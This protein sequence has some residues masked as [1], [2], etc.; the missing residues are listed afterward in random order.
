MDISV[1]FEPVLAALT[2]ACHFFIFGPPL[3][4][5]LFFSSLAL[6]ARAAIMRKWAQTLPLFCVILLVWIY[7]SFHGTRFGIP[8]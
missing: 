8:I 3:K 2:S 4:L 6:A 5:L 1:F 7:V